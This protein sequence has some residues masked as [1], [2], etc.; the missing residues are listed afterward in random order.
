MTWQVICRIPPQ[1][2]YGGRQ[3]GPIPPNSNLIFYI[4]LV[5]LGNTI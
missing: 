4:E 3:V 2:G 1:Y 5:S